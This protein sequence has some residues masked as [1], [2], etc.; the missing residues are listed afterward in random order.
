MNTQMWESFSV[1]VLP[2]Q[3]N[4]GEIVWFLQDLNI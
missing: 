2:M 4:F 3:C 1:V